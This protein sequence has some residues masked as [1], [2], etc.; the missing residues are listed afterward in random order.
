MT[1]KEN[2][3]LQA[4]HDFLKPGYKTVENGRMVSADGLRQSRMK[5]ADILGGHAGGAQ[6]NFEPLAP[7]FYETWENEA[8]R[9]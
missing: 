2:D 6:V 4:E 3:A 9:Q 1:M 5:D 7:K 8:F